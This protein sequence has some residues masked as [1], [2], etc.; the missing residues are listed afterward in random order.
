MIHDS[1]EESLKDALKVFQEQ[2][3]NKESMVN[4]QQN[5]IFGQ[6][7][8]FCKNMVLFGQTQESIRPVLAMFLEKYALNK[9]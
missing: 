2:S 8:N 5:V 7:A 3:I 4:Y 9:E 6:L 1:L